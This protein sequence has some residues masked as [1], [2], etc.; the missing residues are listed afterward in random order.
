[1][2]RVEPHKFRTPRRAGA[3]QRSVAAVETHCN[4]VHQADAQAGLIHGNWRDADY[5]IGFAWVF[6]RCVAAV[7]DNPSDDSADVRVAL[8]AVKCGPFD[9]RDPD[10]MATDCTPLEE[11][12]GKVAE[13]FARSSQGITEVVFQ[14]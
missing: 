14:R 2:H 11:V 1:M 5:N 13:S 9:S 8:Q 4:G 10:R 6:Y 12:P 3:F 7:V